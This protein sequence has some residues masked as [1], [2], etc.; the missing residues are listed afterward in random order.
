MDLWFGDMKVFSNVGYKQVTP[1]IEVP[2]ER[3][4]FKLQN[5]G[6]T[7]TNA[8][9]TNSE[10]LTAGAHYTIV[11]EKKN[12]KDQALTL[13][14]L[15]DDLTLPAEGKAKIRIVNAALGLGKIDVVGPDGKIFSGV[16]DDTST[17]Y[18]DVSAARG[19]L[20][21]RRSDKKVDVL[22]ITNLNL[23]PG[24]IYTIFV[25]GGAGQPIEGVTV[26]DELTPS[27]IGG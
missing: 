25:V 14:S 8:L 9:A 7:Q 20:E 23:Q 6:D 24:K 27:G 3:H 15:N 18:K 16:G 10:G 13:D 17:S 5:S 12:S 1:Y 4:D 11:A 2:A 22:R 19:T 21:V 26:S